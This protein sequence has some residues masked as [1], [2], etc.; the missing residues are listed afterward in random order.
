MTDAALSSVSAVVDYVFERYRL[1]GRWA[2]RRD[3]DARLPDVVPDSLSD[4]DNLLRAV[5]VRLDVLPEDAD[6]ELRADLSTAVHVLSD[7]RFRIAELGRVHRAPRLWLAETDVGAYLRRE[8]APWQ[9]RVTALVRHLAQVPDFLAAAAKTLGRTL[10]A[11]ERISGVETGRARAVAIRELVAGLVAEHPELAGDRLTGVAAAASAACTAFA[12]AVA[13]TEPARAVL[14]PDLLAAYLEAAEG[15]DTPVDELLAEVEAEVANLVARLDALAARLGAGSRQEA[16]ELLNA[17]VP[18]GSVVT[19]L[20][21]MIERLREFWVE[22]DVVTV[23]SRHGLEIRPAREQ[24][25]SAE[26]AFDI[27]GPF[28]TVP[29]PHV[30]YVPEP[31]DPA[32]LR[33]YLN[34]PM[35]EMIAVHEVF[36]GHYLHYEATPPDATVIRRCVPSFPA[37]TEGWAHYT[38]ELAIER[39]LAEGRPLVEVAALRFALEAATRLLVFLSVHSR[40]S[41][42]GAAVAEAAS[43]CGWSPERAAR[44]VLAVVADGSSAMYTLGKLHIRRWRALAGAGDSATELKA[45]H[46][47]LVRCGN[48]PLSTVWRYYLDGQRTPAFA[49]TKENS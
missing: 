31:R 39:G 43:L 40:R 1:I 2:G 44:E 46:D 34:V 35:L 17:Q 19:A 32:A 7:E 27:A 24:A 30:L 3:L 12:D 36:P 9:E 25:T 20:T 6:P 41:R 5:T 15:V 10:P 14:G 18:E 23:T 38:E 26:V 13:A 49:T 11:G 8:Y 4:V 48:A 42:F 28:D 22:Q 29:Q 47:R 45:F 33:D 37:T 16:Y 21:G